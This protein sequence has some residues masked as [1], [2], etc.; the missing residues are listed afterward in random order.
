MIARLL[1]HPL[2]PLVMNN[3][4]AHLQR[5]SGSRLTLMELLDALC[6]MQEAATDDEWDS[7]LRF[8]AQDDA[9]ARVA[10]QL[11]DAAAE[12]DR[13]ARYAAMNGL[14]VKFDVDLRELQLRGVHVNLTAAGRLVQQQLDNEPNPEGNPS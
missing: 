5:H 4:H 13:A 14:E 1:H 8:M 6:R 12:L 3:A 2:G 7:V 9:R 10:W 11:V